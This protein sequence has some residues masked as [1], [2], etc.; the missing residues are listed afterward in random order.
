MELPDVL[1]RFIDLP[2]RSLCLLLK[3]RLEHRGLGFQLG[4]EFGVE[5]CCLM[6]EV[7]SECRRLGADLFSVVL[8][9]PHERCF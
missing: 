8:S 6:L 5:A 2:R 4:V 9:L 1:L 7:A 3:L